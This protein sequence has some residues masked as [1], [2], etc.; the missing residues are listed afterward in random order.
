MK[1]GRVANCF[2]LASERRRAWRVERAS[3]ERETE[4]PERTKARN[5]GAPA[6]S[7]VRRLDSE[8]VEIERRRRI[9]ES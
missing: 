3:S 9:Q 5:S 4:S 6:D 8:S 1:S 2:N 7:R